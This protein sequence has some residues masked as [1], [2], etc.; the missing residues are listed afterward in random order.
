MYFP[1]IKKLKHEQDKDPYDGVLQWF[2]EQTS[3]EL[4]DN[5]TEDEY[6]GA[7]KSIEPLIELVQENMPE[8]PTSDVPFVEELVLW[9]LAE[10]KKLNRKRI[11]SGF[12]FK[13]NYGAYLSNL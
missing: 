12:E 5:G 13:D 6:L 10:Y 1:P 8:L 2:F 11:E 3:F 7:L 4:M 9:A